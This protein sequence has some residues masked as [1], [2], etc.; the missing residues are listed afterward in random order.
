MIREGIIRHDGDGGDQFPDASHKLTVRL[1]TGS[2]V[3]KVLVLSNSRYYR[4]KFNKNADR[5]RMQLQGEIE[6]FRY[7]RGQIVSRDRTFCYCF[8]LIDREG[9]VRYFTGQ[10][11]QNDLPDEPAVGEL[12]HYP[13]IHDG[14]VPDYPDWSK[15]AIVYQ[16]FPDRFA[17]GANENSS[18]DF[19]RWGKLPTRNSHFGG[20]LQGIKEKLDYLEKLGINTL[21][22][23]PVFKSPSNHKYNIDDYYQIDENFGGLS[24]AEELFQEAHSRGFKI[25]LDA[26]FNHTSSRFFAFADIIRKGKKSPYKDWYYIHS[27]PPDTDRVNYEAFAGS[28]SD[29]PRVNLLNREARNYFLEVV[30]HWTE[31]LDVDGWR[32]DVADEVPEEFWRSMRRAV[33]EINPECYLTGE[34]WYRGARWLQGEQ[35]DGV[36]NYYR[37]REII[38]LLRGNISPVDFSRKVKK[39][40]LTCPPGRVIDSLN[41]LDSHDTARIQ[42]SFKEM[43]KNNRRLKVMQAVFLQFTLPGVPVIYYGSEVGINGG[44]DPD[45][46]RCMIWDKEKQDLKLLSFY[47]RL[48]AFYR[49]YPSLTGGDFF[50]ALP[51]AGQNN[52]EL[53][54]FSRISR[55]QNG[56]KRSHIMCNLSDRCLTVY[57]GNIFENVSDKNRDFSACFSLR[58]RTFGAESER[59]EGCAPQNPL[60]DRI[61]MPPYEA[62]ILKK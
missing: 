40:M 14:K 43:E 19:E 13:Y 9:D 20:D 17:R 62:V 41:M 48:I 49:R 59:G 35:F 58:G 38:G 12:F 51:G 26:V 24:A 44:E 2:E 10:G 11:L 50:R 39:Q 29:M 22:L 27:Y 45:N 15:D 4:S 8:K 31:K 53:L 23:T 1:R 36:M 46:R 37:R 18:Q 25:I 57:P 16:I 60:F 54:A 42:N 32:L 61:K 56:Q 55:F 21:Y 7:Y 3:K 5:K 28:V 33:K 47:K 34:V 6:G 52:G 30:R